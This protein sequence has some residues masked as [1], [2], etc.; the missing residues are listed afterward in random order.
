MGCRLVTVSLD[1]ETYEIYQKL[2]LKSQW[3]R[4]QLMKTQQMSDTKKKTL[5]DIDKAINKLASVRENLEN[6]EGWE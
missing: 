2:P 3:I 6:I 5:D 4:D 1:D